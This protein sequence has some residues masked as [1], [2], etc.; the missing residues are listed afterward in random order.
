MPPPFSRN[1][2]ADRLTRVRQAMADKG[3]DLLVV[4]EPANVNWLTGYDAWS[5][6]TP[7]VMVV[8]QDCN[9]T[10]IGREMDAGAAA[11][12]TYLPADQVV[13]FPED[14]VQQAQTHPAAFMGDWMAARGMDG[15]R[16]GYE[17]DVYFLTPAAVGHLKAKLPNSTWSDCAL[18]VN[19]QRLIKSPAEIAML[20]QA[21]VIAGKAMQTAYDGVRPGVRQCDLMAE[22]I[23]AQVRGTPEFGGDMTALH[24]LV[25]AGEAASTAHP[26]WTDAPFEKDQT[27]AFE[28]G[29]C[30]KRYNAGLARTAHLGKPPEALVTTAKAVGEG[31]DEV[32]NAMKS[33]VLC[34]DVHA[35][36]QA[37]LDRYGL[38]KKSRIG[39][40]IGVGYS[41]DWGEHTIS[42]RPDD[43]TPL[44]ENAVVHIILGMWMEGWGMELSETIHVR[45][46]DAVCLTQFPRDVNV[47]DI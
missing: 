36:W 15:Q 7:Q 31:M 27:I 12:T 5:F 1:E 23:A 40:S 11:F 10:W 4:G 8:G 2:Y 30:R 35:A 18:L 14:L 25:L 42:F 32:L 21:A 43:R 26:M 24:P 20:Q 39:Y 22:I 17:S 37:V 45:D 19:W 44:P 41:P 28:L 33:D 9:P 46:R 38:E 3:F 29:G 6:Y 16:I 13:S 34:C 47:I